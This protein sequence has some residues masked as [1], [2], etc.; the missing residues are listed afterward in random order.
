MNFYNIRAFPA[1]SLVRSVRSHNVSGAL[2]LYTFLRNLCHCRCFVGVGR[3]WRGLI[4]GNIVA[5][6]VEKFLHCQSLP[7]VYMHE[8]KTF[9][10]VL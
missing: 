4:T 3:D 7:S 8:G 10:L 1:V 6:L 5:S 9:F 2:F